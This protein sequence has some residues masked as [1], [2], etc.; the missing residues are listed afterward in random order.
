MYNT[1][2]SIITVVKDERANLMKTLQSLNLQ[3]SDDFEWIIIDGSEFPILD[4]HNHEAIPR[5]SFFYTNEPDNG[6][7]EAMNRGL[8]LAKGQYLLF[9]NAGDI[10]YGPMSVSVFIDFLSSLIFNPDLVFMGSVSIFNGRRCLRLPSKRIRNMKYRMPSSHQSILYRNA[11]ICA[12]RL[13]YDNTFRI[14]GDFDHYLRCISHHPHIAFLDSILSVFDTEGI[15]SRRPQQLFIESSS[16]LFKT[17]S[18]LPAVVNSIRLLK[19]LMLFQ[20]L[21]FITNLVFF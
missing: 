20:L 14:C 15:S 10:F 19:S 1:T 12:N 5:K 13:D 3:E 8:Y 2:L 21:K 4:S 6:I 18:M 7:Y 16:L 17:Y 9:L 11:F